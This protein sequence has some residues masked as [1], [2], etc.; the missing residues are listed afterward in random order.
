MTASTPPTPPTPAP[1]ILGIQ[2]QRIRLLPLDAALHL[3]NYLRWFNDPEVTRYLSRSLPMTRPEEEAFFKRPPSHPPTDVVWAVHDEHDRH[4]GGTGL[5]RIDWLNRSALSGTVIGEKSAWRQ[6]YGTEIMRLRTRWAFE[7]LGLHRIESE[8][9]VDNE[10]SAACLERAGYRRIGTAREKHYRNGRW[11]D[12]HLF[13]ILA[14]DWRARHSEE[15][16][17]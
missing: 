13:E 1:Q 12:A 8:C 2:G 9:F 16:P 4:I 6:G 17:A 7:E 5:H 10:G 14:S 15:D 3:D 11:H